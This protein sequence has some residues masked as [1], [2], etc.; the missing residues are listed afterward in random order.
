MNIMNSM[1]EYA[2]RWTKS[3]REELDTLS[4]WIKTIRN[5]LKFLIHHLT[6][7]M[8]T[9]YPS[10]FKKLEVVNELHR[11]HENFVLV[12]AD[13]AS[14]NI[15]FVCKSYYYNCLLNELGFT[16]TS[17]NP[18]YTPSNFTKDEILQNHLSDLNTFNI[19]KNQDQFELSYIYCNP[20]LHKN[21]YKQRYIA[22]SSKCST[23]P[24]SLF[25]TKLL[26][27][28]KESL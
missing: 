20:K 14:N 8:C 2:R 23:K 22:G 15:V 10:V 24:L 25:L 16:S 11:L 21:P 9:I 3:E 6:G 7:K 27:A 18:T 17:G 13:K 4:E 1:E 12:P 26:T 5:L 19:P 28:I